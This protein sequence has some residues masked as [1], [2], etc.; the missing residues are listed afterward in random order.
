ML[1]N[2][3][4]ETQRLSSDKLK[5]IVDEAVNQ[6]SGVLASINGDGLRFSLDDEF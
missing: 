1:Y 4:S 6:K 3:L 5:E 2:K